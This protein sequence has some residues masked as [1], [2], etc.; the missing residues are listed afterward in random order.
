[1]NNGEYREAIIYES[2]CSETFL[3]N[4]FKELLKELGKSDSQIM[5]SLTFPEYKGIK[6]LFSPRF[7]PHL[8]GGNWNYR[9]IHSEIGKWHKY[10][11][12]IRNNV[13]HDGYTPE[14]LDVKRSLDS[15]DVFRLWVLTLLKSKKDTFP[16]TNY[17]YSL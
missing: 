1:M 16:H 17:L 15:N 12:L 13:V 3:I 6:T 8:L 14:Y 10:S 7:L 9:D 5:E 11:Y 2:I 4:I